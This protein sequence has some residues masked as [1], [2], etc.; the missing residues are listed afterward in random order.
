MSTIAKVQKVVSDLTGR[1]VEEHQA[2]T[3]IVRRGPGVDRAVVLDVLPD[4]VGDL[5]DANDC[6]VVELRKH[7]ETTGQ[8]M[9]VTLKN[10]KAIAPDGKVDELLDNARGLRGRPPGAKSR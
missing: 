4:E 5:T 3:L 2:L 1:E 10:F 8:E 6:Y 9:V 7:G